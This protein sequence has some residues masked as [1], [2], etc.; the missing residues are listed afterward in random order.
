MVGDET[1]A[2]HMEGLSR[3]QKSGPGGTG[4]RML[5]KE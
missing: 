2:E 5:T 4:D 3:R 1:H